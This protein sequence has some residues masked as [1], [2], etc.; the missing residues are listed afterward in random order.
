MQILIWKSY[1][2]IRVYCAESKEQLSNIADK[3]YSIVK[4]WQIMEEDYDFNLEYNNAVAQKKARSF[5][6]NFVDDY[7]NDS[8]SFEQFYF[9]TVRYD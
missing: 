9:D 7:C 4:D 1:G 6:K 3:V 2:D 5:L 8:D